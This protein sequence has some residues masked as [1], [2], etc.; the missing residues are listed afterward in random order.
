M[1]T[2]LP[3]TEG[4]TLVVEASD[5]L[6][7]QDYEE[8]FIPTLERLIRQYGKIRTVFYLSDSFSG[9]E[10]GAMWDDA[11]FGVKHCNDFER[12]ALVGGPRWMAWLTK[13]S[14]HFMHCEVKTFDQGALEEAIAWTK[15]EAAG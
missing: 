6:T 10:L 12:L 9:W 3:A 13:L 1:I 14:G 11:K 7:T 5:K 2:I 4:R 15:E 8:V